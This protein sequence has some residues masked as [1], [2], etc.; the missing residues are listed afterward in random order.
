MQSLKSVHLH[1]VNVSYEQKVKFR[2]QF[3]CANESRSERVSIRAPGIKVKPGQGLKV[4]TPP[5]L[6]CTVPDALFGWRVLA[7]GDAPPPK[8]EPKLRNVGGRVTKTVERDGDN[9]R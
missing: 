5:I 4:D 2:R 9:R 8:E 7:W 1:E 6:Q 3:L